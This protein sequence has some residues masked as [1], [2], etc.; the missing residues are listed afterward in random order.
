MKKILL[1]IALAFAWHHFY[2]IPT[3]DTLK[4]GVLVDASPSQ[5]STTLAAFDFEKYELIP[6]ANFYVQAQVLSAERYYFDKESRLSPVDLA[7]GWGPMSDKAVLDQL[8]IWQEGRWYKWQA[9]NL[10]ISR[11]QIEINSGNMHMIPAN[12][13]IA[14]T[15][16]EIRIGSVVV[17]EGLLVDVSNKTG[18]K[19]K[20]STSRADVGQGA[21]EIVYVTRIETASNY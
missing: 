6:R 2:Y 21:C 18:W 20:T 8:D 5:E 3:D 19:W 7:L 15:L 10:P 1:I 17:I 4:S 9:N 12:D 16:K 13:E 14:Q 11:K